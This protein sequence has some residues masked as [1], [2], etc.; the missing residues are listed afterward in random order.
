MSLRYRSRRSVESA[1]ESLLCV[2]GLAVGIGL[3]GLSLAYGPT[4]LFGATHEVRPALG[5]QQT[6]WL[7]QL[8]AER[9]AQA[10]AQDSV[11]ILR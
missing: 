8:D 4:R 3:V 11:T 5:F 9:L 2:F 6:Q 7:N 1:Q 10:R